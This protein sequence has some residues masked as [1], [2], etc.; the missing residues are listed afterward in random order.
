MNINWY[1][2]HMVKAKKEIIENLKVV[3][4]V[5]EIVD[6]RAP[7]ATQNPDIQ[8][9]IKSKKTLVVLNKADLADPNTNKKWIKYFESQGKS[10]V[11]VNAVQGTGIKETIVKINE[12]AKDKQEEAKAKGREGRSIK[13]MVIGIPNV[14]KSSFINRISKKT[15]AKVGNKPGVTVKQQWIRVTENIDLLDTPGILWPRMED[16]KVKL[17][18]AYIGSIKD[19]TFEKEELAYSLIDTLRK[20]YPEKIKERFGIEFDDSTKTLEIVEN[21]GRKRG[22]L[23][24]GGQVDLTKVS[25]IIIEDF[26]KGSIGRI[27]L[28]WT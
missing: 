24:S 13:V 23:I 19:E 27:S 1:P 8:N 18:L 25:N 15:S 28:E 7:K 21:I 11:E 20:T 4:V 17:D 12:L 14:G 22:C 10:A 26:R 3:D 2:G 5:V 9:Y 16:N 6:A